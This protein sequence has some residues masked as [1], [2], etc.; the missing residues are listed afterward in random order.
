MFTVAAQREE[1]P[2]EWVDA[3]GKQRW[4]VD[5]NTAVQHMRQQVRQNKVERNQY[6]EHVYRLRF[7]IR[8]EDDWDTVLAVGGAA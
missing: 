5:Y 3:P 2:G 7:E 6:G 4:F 8:D 1:R